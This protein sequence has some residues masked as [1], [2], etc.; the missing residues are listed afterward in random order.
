MK[1]ALLFSL[2]PLLLCS[3]GGGNT[4][5]SQENTTSTPVEKI[6][7]DKYVS[8]VASTAPFMVAGVD[9]GQKVDYVVSS[10]PVVFSAMNNKDKKTDLSI[11]SSVASLFSEKYSTKG[12]P[13]AG[14]LIKAELYNSFVKGEDTNLVSNVKVFLSQFDKDVD[15]LV[16]GGTNSVALLNA[17]SQDVTQQAARFGFN[18]NVIKAVQKDNL[19][20]FL[21]HKDNPTVEGLRVFQEPLGVNIAESDL[22]TSLY[23]PSSTLDESTPEALPFH[24]ISPKG[25]PAA[26]LARYAS[27]SEHLEVAAPDNVKATFSAKNYDFV[28]FDAVNG[29]KLSKANQDSYKLVRMVTFGNLYVIATGNDED[30]TLSD[31]DYIVSFGKG[32][33]PDLAFQAVYSK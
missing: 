29:V 27:D 21:S 3:C 5:N 1:K 9:E 28:I 2:L 30:K 16:A 18:A 23:N 12:F 25:A 14:L 32:L 4:T 24:V 33:V 11:Y 8:D 26:A 17:Y 15:D 10:Y 20:S 31:D 7:V 19:L 13:Q 22:A 6:T